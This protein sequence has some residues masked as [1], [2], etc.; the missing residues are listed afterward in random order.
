MMEKT[1]TPF[2][3][4]MNLPYLHASY[5]I[6]SVESSPLVGANNFTSSTPDWREGTYENFKDW[7]SKQFGTKE[8]DS[9]D[10]AEVPV[11]MT[12]AKLI[13]FERNKRGDL[14]LPPMTDYKTVRQKQRVIRG[15]IGA[16]YR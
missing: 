4:S 13:P 5:L 12:K 11:H 14:I 6:S 10:E 2:S 16:V 9:D 7:A 15:Y 8:F 1:F 3:W